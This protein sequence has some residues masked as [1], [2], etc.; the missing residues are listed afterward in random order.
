M[1]IGDASNPGPSNFVFLNIGKEESDGGHSDDDESQPGQLE[2]WLAEIVE[3]PCADDAAATSEL[4]DD[5]G[6]AGSHSVHGDCDHDAGTDSGYED[7]AAS[8]GEA[9]DSD[10]ARAGTCFEGGVHVPCWDWHL[11]SEQ[12]G[13]WSTTEVTNK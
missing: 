4:G 11:N 7:P 6:D 1:R 8:D 3:E 5:A 13:V 10:D 12:R 9:G 2:D